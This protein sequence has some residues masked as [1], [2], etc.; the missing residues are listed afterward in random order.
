MRLGQK[1]FIVGCVFTSLIFLFKWIF[2][3]G[4]AKFLEKHPDTYV[5]L[6]GMERS[7]DFNQL[8]KIAPLRSKIKIVPVKFPEGVSSANDIAIPIK[9][10]KWT[11]PK[12]T[13]FYILVAHNKGDGVDRKIKIDIN[14]E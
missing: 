11:Y 10:F 5:Y 6:Y 8:K 2:P 4:E 13:K 9:F 7:Y 14:S 3:Y 12:N 1:I